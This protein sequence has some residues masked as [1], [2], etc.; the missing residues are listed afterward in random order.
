M[1]KK[2]MIARDVK[3]SKMIERFAAKRAAFKEAMAAAADPMERLEIHRKLQGLPRNSAPSRHRNRCWATGKPR[4]FYR[5]FGLC[6]NQLRERAHK[7]ELP[8]VVKSSW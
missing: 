5:D 7:G 8:G 3:R 4:G 6:R 1:A 2:S